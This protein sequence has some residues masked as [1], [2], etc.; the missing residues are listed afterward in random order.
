MYNSQLIIRGRLVIESTMCHDNQ[1]SY[2]SM[3]R[4][5]GLRSGQ[6]M[7]LQTNVAILNLG[8]SQEVRSVIM[9]ELYRGNGGDSL[10]NQRSRQS[11]GGVGRGSLGLGGIQSCSIANMYL[12]A[13]IFKFRGE[14][15]HV[16]WTGRGRQCNI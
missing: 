16:C 12:E 4:I 11:F 3:L 1:F 9:R 8:V 14:H 5:S 2:D 15:E 10:H 13:C 7:R 6:G